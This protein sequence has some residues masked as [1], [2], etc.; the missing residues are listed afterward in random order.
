MSQANNQSTP[1]STTPSLLHGH[2]QYI[3]G[4]IEVAVGSLTS[5]PSLQQSGQADK[6]SAVV[7]L[8]AA[9]AATQGQRLDNMEHRNKD[10]LGREGKAEEILGSTVSCA[11]L[12]KR[13][14]E[15]ETAAHK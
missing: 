1:A 9:D 11:G 10:W 5:S 12:Q 14:L 3:K 2:A 8:R 13:G 7:E 6:A 4:T 15:K